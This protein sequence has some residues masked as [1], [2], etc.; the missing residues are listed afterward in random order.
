[1]AFLDGDFFPFPRISVILV[2]HP[3]NV[4]TGRIVAY[5]DFEIV[6]R[7]RSAHPKSDF[8][9]VRKRN[10]E[11]AV[12]PSVPGSLS[13]QNVKSERSPMNSAV[14][15]ARYFD[16]CRLECFPILA[17]VACVKERRLY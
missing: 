7:N 10:I 1:M 12:D 3:P 13:E 14:A 8:I 4:L 9:I 11:V 17:F 5:F 2:V 16:T 6:H 15:A